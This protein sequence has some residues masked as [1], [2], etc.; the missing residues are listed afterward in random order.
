MWNRVATSLSVV[1]LVIAVA[2]LV[3]ALRDD[4]NDEPGRRFELRNLDRYANDRPVLFED[5]EFYLVRHA[6]P[7]EGGGTFE[8]WIALYNVVPHVYFGLSQGC[9]ITW[10]PEET[11]DSNSGPITGV[12]RE[13]CSG[14]VFD[15]VGKH[16]FGPANRNLD[17]FLAIQ[18]PDEPVIIDT[19]VLFCEGAPDL[20]CRRTAASP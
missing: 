10:R 20:P 9:R 3:A 16:L 11:F 5:D 15:V 7:R 4:S 17:Q 18:F 6:E 14:S 19:R 2:A 12:F 13:G 8:R 1:A